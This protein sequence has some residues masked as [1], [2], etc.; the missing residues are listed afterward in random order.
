M[1]PETRVQKT[2]M[3]AMKR[4]AKVVA[5]GLVL[6]AGCQDLNVPN[7]NQP[8]VDAAFATPGNVETAVGASFKT[9]WAAVHSDDVRQ[10]VYYYPSAG[11]S[12]LGGEITSA[13]T[14]GAFD[15]VAGEPRAPYNNFDAGQWF[16]RLPY[17]QLYASI[18]M[19]TDV[20]RTLDKGMKIGPVDAEYP[21]GRY[22]HRARTWAKL[23]QGMGHV[24]AGLYFDKGRVVDEKV[25]LDEYSTDFRPYQEVIAHGVKQLEEAVA[26]ANAAASDTLTSPT[27]W[28]NGFSYKYGDVA[29]LANSFIARALVYG[30]RNPQERA[31][32]DWNR[33]LNLVNSGI[34]AS[35]YSFGS[36]NNVGFIQQADNSIRGTRSLYVNMVQLQT[37]ARPSN[38]L[39]GPS[40]TSGRYQ[41]WL[42]TPLGERAAVTFI[43]PDRRIHGAGGPTTSGTIFR[44]LSSQTMPTTRGTH[45]HSNYRSIKYGTNANA[46]NTAVLSTMTPTEMNFIKAEALMRLGRAAEALPLINPSR[47][48]A[49]L[50][51]ATVDGV[52]GAACVPRKNSGACGDLWDVLQY[53]KRIMTYGV[54]STIPFADARGWGKLLKGSMVHMPVPGRELQTLGMEY[55]SFGGDLPGS[56]P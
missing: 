7:Y 42:N 1:R 52:S 31:A 54:E 15:E 53:E 26:L 14:L 5:G 20:L 17:Q 2:P 49:G 4:T 16:N 46:Y 35:G 29:K 38:Y 56:A 37:D 43:T 28:V 47:V 11:L 23:I 12:G 50:P 36:G 45:L 6:V 22:T 19:A 8:S 30:A 44:Y 40:D 33:V 32:A 41:Q 25:P 21:N 13:G 48:A 24:Y 51:A 55:Y 3:T 39:L 18:A 9:W 27:N 10:S 34:I